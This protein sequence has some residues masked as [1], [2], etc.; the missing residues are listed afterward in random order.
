MDEDA[1]SDSQEIRDNLLNH[2]ILPRVL[3]QDKPERFIELKLMTHMIE[4]V[5][6]LANCLP[7]KTVELFRRLKRVHHECSPIVISE[8]IKSLRPGDTFAMF[9][10]R[11]NTV[12][13]IYMLPNEDINNRSA[14]NV[15]LSTF[16]ATLHPNQIYATES[17]IKVILQRFLF[18]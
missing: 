8:E 13:M 16:P 4:N 12:F 15:I 14:Q 11:Q 3:P 2:I 7:E 10:R 17:D 9:V 18:D 1:E 6:D 5:E